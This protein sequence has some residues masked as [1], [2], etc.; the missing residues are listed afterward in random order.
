VHEVSALEL[1]PTS[2][3]SRTAALDARILEEALA[4]VARHGLDETS[5]ASLAKAVGTSIGP[6]YARYDTMEDLAVDLWQHRVRAHLRSL[7]EL[8]RASSAGELDARA[9]LAAELATPSVTSSAL[10]ELL[11]VARRHTYLRELIVDDTTSDLEE[12][13]AAQRGVPQ[14]LAVTQADVLLGGLFVAPVGAALPSEDH[15]GVLTLLG[16]ACD[17]PIARAATPVPAEPATLP[18]PALATGDELVDDFTKAVMEVIAQVGYAK[19]SANRIARRAGHGFSAVYSHYDSKDEFMEAAVNLLIDQL[20]TTSVEPFIGVERQAFI[21]AS[22]ANAK[23]LVS[24]AN[25]LNR[26]LRIE[27]TLAARHHPVLAEHMNAGYE[28][29]LAVG[30]SRYEEHYPDFD[31]ETAAVLRRIWLLIRSN[32]FGLSLLR[33]C[34]PELAQIEW[35]PASTALRD[36]T[37]AH[38]LARLG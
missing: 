21:E 9:E 6:I 15:A 10:V 16:E 20:L 12:H 22:V 27:I 5:A 31:D 36:L 3:K 29:V 14:S 18:L 26:H 2:R 34:A 35:T 4:M 17:D 30:R 38:L 13:V 11:A 19:A 8:V 1:R 32:G 25:R 33:S 7:L 37:E 28:A 24:E 23:G